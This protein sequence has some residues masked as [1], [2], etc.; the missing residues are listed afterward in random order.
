MKKLFISTL[1]LFSLNAFSQTLEVKT[2]GDH[3][4]KFQK[5]KNTALIVAGLSSLFLLLPLT[6]T[7]DQ[8]QAPAIYALVGVGMM[9]SFS[10]NISAIQQV[11]KA[12][13]LIKF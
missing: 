5:K 10:L 3:L 7:V 12:G 6:G 11:G 9:V 8:D 13:R 1:L 4:I 2:A